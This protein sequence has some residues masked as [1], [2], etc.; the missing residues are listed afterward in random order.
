[1]ARGKILLVGGYRLE[2]IQWDHPGDDL[3][4]V[5][6]L[7]L[8]HADELGRSAALIVVLVEQLRPVARADVRPL[9]VELRRVVRHGKEDAKQF[10]IAHP[11]SVVA[12][13]DRFRDPGAVEGWITAG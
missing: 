2:V 7:A 11:R 6:L 9:P 12:D 8:E 5:P 4:R 1:M 10:N 13:C 3:P